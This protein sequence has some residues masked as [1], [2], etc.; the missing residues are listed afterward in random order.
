MLLAGA[1]ILAG[2]LAF[3]GAA[4]LTSPLAARASTTG[5]SLACSTDDRG[6]IWPVRARP[7]SRWLLVP[8]GA[9]SLS[10]CRYNG[11]NAF[12]GVPQFGLLGAGVTADHATISRLSDELD[13]LKPS[14]GTIHCPFDDGSRDV[15]SFNYASGPS[16][17]VTVGTNGC[18]QI[19][20][21]HVRRLGLARPLV[22][23]LSA[24]AK[25]V[26]GLKWAS[27]VGRI[28]LC[29]GPAP[30][31]CWFQKQTFPYASRAVAT[32]SAGLWVAMAQLHHNRFRLTI[33]TPGPYRFEL[34]G[35]GKH[36]NTVVSRTR[37]TV[38]A[39]STTNVVFTIPV[40]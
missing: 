5:R 19:S 39:G 28:R 29:G 16:V 33:A 7:D 14:R 12:G 23:Q 31:R 36:V 37:A 24:L 34:M 30:G 9:V 26:A 22:A 27:V 25:P 18:N 11:M 40:P 2:M 6:R 8:R 3:I 20:N 17:V 35:S 21:G 10:V 38:R 15:A 13:A 4:P 1:F 32:N